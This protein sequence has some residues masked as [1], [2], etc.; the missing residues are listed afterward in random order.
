MSN[1]SLLVRSDSL[2]HDCASDFI[3]SFEELGLNEEVH[4]LNLPRLRV[5]ILLWPGFTLLAFSGFVDALR[6]AADI[7]DRSRQVHCRWDVMAKSL[8]PVSSS[9]GVKVTPNSRFK[10]PRHFDYIVVVAGLL[11]KIHDAPENASKYLMQSASIGVPLVGI[12][13]GSFVIAGLGLLDGYRACPGSYHY[14]EF[15]E[16]FPQVPA[17]YDQLYCVDRDRITCSGGAASIDLA[18]YLVKRHCGSDRAT[19]ISYM[20]IVDRLRRPDSPQRILKFKNERI[21]DVRVSRV[22]GLMEQNMAK[23]MLITAIARQLEINERQLE[24]IFVQFTGLSPAH[25]YRRIRLQFGCWL[26]VNT[27]AAI[28]SIALD[29]GFS[30]NAHFTRCFRK[31]F[32]QAP[33]HYRILQAE[34]AL[35]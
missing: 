16:C 13:T 10:D 28:T 34:Q 1:L 17:N 3:R 30:D 21:T 32:G 25:Y 9:C 27:K 26:L 33:S 20:V 15:L 22:I 8:E 4:S 31:E 18:A 35:T 11:D 29:C 23:P 7:G 2:R 24:R 14:K 12:C 6:L 19:K 5:G